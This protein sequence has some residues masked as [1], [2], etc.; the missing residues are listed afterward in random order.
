MNS[1]QPQILAPPNSPVFSSEFRDITTMMNEACE[2]LFLRYQ[3]DQISP[4]QFIQTNLLEENIM[5]SSCIQD[6]C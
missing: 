4:H 2:Q 3:P 5:I 6:K 1:F